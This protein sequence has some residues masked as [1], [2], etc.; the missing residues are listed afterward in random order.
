MQ[1]ADLVPQ[2]SGPKSVQ[3]LVKKMTPKITNQI[4]VLGRSKIPRDIDPSLVRHG[5]SDAFWRG[6]GEGGCLR[7]F[8]EGL[9]ASKPPLQG[10]SPRTPKCLQD[11]PRPKMVPRCSPGVPR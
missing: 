4:A 10:P 6:F 3:K 8:G 9:E 7:G 5:A 11:V 2:S 1:D